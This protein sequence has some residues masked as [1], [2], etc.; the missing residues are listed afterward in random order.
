MHITISEVRL[1]DPLCNT[2]SLTP[3]YVITYMEKEPPRKHVYIYAEVN[4][5]Q[6]IEKKKRKN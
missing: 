3:H 4:Q 2:R 5:L 6:H 1:Q